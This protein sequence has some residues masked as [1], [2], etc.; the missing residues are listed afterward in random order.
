MREKVFPQRNRPRR[1]CREKHELCKP[2][3]V[4]P[5]RRNEQDLLL[6][7]PDLAQC[8]CERAHW[9]KRIF[10]KA[11]GPAVCQCIRAEGSF[12]QGIEP[13]AMGRVRRGKQIIAAISGSGSD[14]ATTPEGGN[15]A[16]SSSPEDDR[17]PSDAAIDI[18][19]SGGALKET[20]GATRD[21]PAVPV[22][23][24]D[25]SDTED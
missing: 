13:L 20:T 5:I 24:S 19:S 4:G 12:G 25:G 17:S 8:L 9:G 1:G 7:L 22:E 10:A 18:W 2:S 15:A 21:G 14:N 23:D 16:E 3:P 6:V 11:L